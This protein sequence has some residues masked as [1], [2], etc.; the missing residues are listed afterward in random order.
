MLP[1]PFIVFL[2]ESS[3]DFGNRF[4]VLAISGLIGFSINFFRIGREKSYQS[5]SFTL[6]CLPLIVLGIDY[7]L[8]EFNYWQF[9]VPLALFLVSFHK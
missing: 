6:M 3:V 9:Y 1:I 4:Q 5:L 7:P 8:S 2:I